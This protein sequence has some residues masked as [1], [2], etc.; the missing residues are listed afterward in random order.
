MLKINRL[1]KKYNQLQVLK[2]ISFDIQKGELVTLMGRSGSGKSTLLQIIGLLDSAD[3]GEVFFDNSNILNFND[4]E[5]S[6]FRNVKMG[7]VFQF[8]HLLEEFTALENV[9][10]PAYIN[11]K[12]EKE[13]QK[14]AISLLEKLNMSHR[15]NHL[16]SQLSGGEQ[17]RVAVARALINDPAI[18]LADEPTGN[19]D[20]TNSIELFSILKSL[21]QDNDVIVLMATHHELFK[22]DS[23]RVIYIQDGIIVN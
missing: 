18:I 4:K 1:E 20:S 12:N 6:N 17:Q 22:N 14:K 19:L 15:I 13:T 21:T 11:G 16:P 23:D 7:F 5:R 2:G 8:H 9:C 10:I 3:S